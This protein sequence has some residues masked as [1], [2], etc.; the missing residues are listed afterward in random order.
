MIEVVWENPP[1]PASHVRAGYP[2]CKYLS[3][4]VIEELVQHPGRWACVYRNA[5]HNVVTVLQQWARRHIEFHIVSRGTRESA[6]V[7]VRYEGRS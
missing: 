2:D 6:D 4:L 5:S 1:P 7:Y 3:E